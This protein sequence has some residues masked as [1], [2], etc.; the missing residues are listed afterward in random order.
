MFSVSLTAQYDSVPAEEPYN[1]I[2]LT[3]ESDRPEVVDSIAFEVQWIR[4]TGPAEQRP[5]VEDSTTSI[6]T[7]ASDPI[8][9][10]TATRTS[11]GQY[12]YYCEI[13]YLYDGTSVA[14]A[15]S[16]SRGVTLRGIVSNIHVGIYSAYILCMYS[17]SRNKFHGI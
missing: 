4:E 7:D 3:C 2:Q 5:V 13:D 17:I 8:S 11:P 15:S 14:S 6:E 12:V 10:L 1:T 16:I 9:V